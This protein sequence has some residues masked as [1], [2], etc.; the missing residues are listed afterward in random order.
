MRKLLLLTA[1]ILVLAL[2]VFLGAAPGQAAATPGVDDDTILLGTFTAL[3]G[4][5][6]PIGVP[7]SHGYLAYYNYINEKGG[8]YGRKIKVLVE[9]DAF[10]PSRTV[11]AVK[12][13]VEQERVFAIVSPLGTP[14]NAAVL[15]YLVKNNVPVISPH[16]GSSQWSIPVKKNYIALQPN[17]TVE[18]TVLAQYALK[19]LKGKRFAIVYVNDDYGQEESKSFSAYLAKNDIKPVLTLGHEFGETDFSSYV[20]K[21]QQAKPDAVLLASYAT[22]TASILKQ[23]E[24]FGFR[25]HFLG[26]YVVSDPVM[27]KLAG[28][29][30]ME[31]FQVTGYA[32]DPGGDTKVAKEYRDILHKYYPNEAPGGYSE[33]GYIAAQL[34]VEALKKAGPDLTRE[35]FIAAFESLKNWTTGLLP[36]ISYSATD[37]RGVKTFVI[38]K[39]KGGQ[40]TIGKESIEVE[41]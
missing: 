30:A 32:A 41:D 24:M 16:T 8:I 12:K 28:A 11:A 17:Y 40:W 23:A 26:T 34:V 6:A 19:D 2:A 9:D 7:N 33:I 36:P 4:P 39:A 15:D 21:L 5:V 10:Q 31:G 20:I 37:H 14:T 3:S 22:Q 13:L 18:G 1:T 29:S 25:P 35:K 27:F 38:A